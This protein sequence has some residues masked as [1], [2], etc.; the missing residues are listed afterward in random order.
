M[1]KRVGPN[2]YV[3]MDTDGKKKLSKPMSRK[4][5]LRQLKSAKPKDA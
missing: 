4:R 2:K 3:I 1:I 5:A